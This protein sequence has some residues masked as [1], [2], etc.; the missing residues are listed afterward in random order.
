MS[1]LN[2]LPRRMG[3]LIIL[4][5]ALWVSGFSL[6][7]LARHWG[8]PIPVALFFSASY[9][10]VALLAADYALS[11]VKDGAS[12]RWPRALVVAFA[13]ASA[14]LNSQ[15][16]VIAGEPSAGR[17]AWAVPP[18]A[19]AVAYDLHTRSE[20][21]KALV[22]A[23]VSYA[24]PAPHFGPLTWL[25]FPGSTINVLREIIERRRLALVLREQKAIGSLEEPKVAKESAAPR[26]KA[27]P[28]RASNVVNIG[29]AKPRLSRAKSREIREWWRAQGNQIG[30]RGTIHR[31]VLHAYYKAHPDEVAEMAASP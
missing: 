7:W 16:A 28:P 20:R 29:D 23:E 24:R 12:D 31:H 18:V 22:K 17:I 15:H 9:D 8:V 3:W 13:A 4:T 25:L 1:N 30:D 27:S 26:A 21:R 19:A 10:G 11:A 5:G 2:G 14:W 6:F